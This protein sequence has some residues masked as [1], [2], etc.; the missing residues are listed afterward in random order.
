MGMRVRSRGYRLKLLIMLVSTAR[1]SMVSVIELI[2]SSIAWLME[3]CTIDSGICC[4][5][6]FTIAWDS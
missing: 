5:V 2:R 6:I 1:L 4:G 3:D